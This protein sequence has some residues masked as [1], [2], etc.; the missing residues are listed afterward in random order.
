[1]KK[2]FL[3]LAVLLLSVAAALWLHD[4]TGYVLVHVNGLSVQASL[5]LAVG[6]VLAG[7]LALYFLLKLLWALWH[8][9]RDMRGWLRRRRQ[10]M[11]RRRLMRGMRR[12]AEG[13]FRGAEQDFARAAPTSDT[14]LIHYLG[15]AMA[16]HRDGASPRRDQYLALADQANPEARLAVGLVQAQ[17]HVE[18]GQYETGFATLNLLQEQWPRQAR[19]LELLALCCE[20]LDE[21]DR[22]LQILPVVQRHARLPQER[23]RTLER[24]AAC[25]ALEQ[26]AVA[27]DQERL[28]RTW[29]RLPRAICQ[30]DA[31]LEAYVDGLLL[32]DA[33]SDE[34]ERLLRKAL[35]RNWDAR[36]LRRLVRLAPRNP[37]AL[38]STVEGWLKQHPEDP[39]LL[40]AAGKLSL[41]AGL[42][43]QARS[44]LEAAEHRA[45]PPEAS[46]LLAALLE[47]RGDA[48]QACRHYQRGLETA[49]GLEPPAEL[50]QV[51]RDPAASA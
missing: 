26:A 7:A 24:R 34:A 23:L 47:R 37:S 4:Q 39:L 41:R 40:L 12:L 29:A 50:E 11:S 17:L 33:S 35:A 10:L 28:R 46:Y 19:V 38:L 31:V 36:W 30:D 43:G 49:A 2:L 3:I 9:P 22:L 13:D 5:F 6:V 1:M 27:L 48:E 8:G 21:W 25:G 51:H 15:A 44:F 32:C 20:R 45:A 42:W 18:D 14:P 16:A